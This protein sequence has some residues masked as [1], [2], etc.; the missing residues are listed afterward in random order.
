MDHPNYIVPNKKDESISASRV[1]EMYDPGRA[2]KLYI[3]VKI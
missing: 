2:I 1:K 3:V